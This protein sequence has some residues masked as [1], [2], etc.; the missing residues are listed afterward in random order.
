MGRDDADRGDVKLLACFSGGGADGSPQ[1][2]TEAATAVA[3]THASSDF[4]SLNLFH[5][6]ESFG[7]TKQRRSSVA[8][9][10]FALTA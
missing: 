3:F 4:L 6:V 7:R 1:I 10:V 8:S 9:M 2:E 5:I